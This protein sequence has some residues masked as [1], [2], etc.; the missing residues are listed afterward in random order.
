MNL[1]LDHLIPDSL[2]DKITI[3]SST[4]WNQS[5]IFDGSDIVKIEAPSGTGKTTLTHLLYKVRSDYT[6]H[7]KYGNYELGNGDEDRL[8]DLRQNHLSIV[9]QDL[10][11]FP[12][13]S[14]KENIEIKRLLTPHFS[15]KGL[16]IEMAE[17]LGVSSIL[18]QKI[19]FCSFGEQQRIAIIRAMVQPFNW[20]IL[21][22]PFS[23]LDQLNINLAS[24]LIE[25][26]CKQRNAGLIIMGLNKDQYFNYTKEMVL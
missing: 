12:D 10:R 7:I 14:A 17:K 21:D 25:S 4:I 23:H 22:E 19:R 16:V 26:A 6:G 1:T 8:A 9:F 15:S 2:K 3:S 13:L 24:K 20:L 11:L 18:D 5:V